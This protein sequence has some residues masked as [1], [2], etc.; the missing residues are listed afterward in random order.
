MKNTLRVQIFTSQVKRLGHQVRSNSDVHTVT[1][2]KLEDRIVGTV[3]V[4]IFSNFQ[5]E[6]LEWMPTDCKFRI[7]HLSDLRTGQFS[8]QRIIAL[9]KK[10][11]LLP[12]TFDQR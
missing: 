5:D 7:F 10:T 3:L 6:V 11:I 9:W 8:T 1:G 2:F 4:R 12:I